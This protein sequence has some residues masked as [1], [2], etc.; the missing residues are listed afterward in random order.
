VAR[1]VLRETL[2]KMSTNISEGLG[3]TID[4]YL[5]VTG[6]REQNDINQLEFKE[7]TLVGPDIQGQICDESKS[8]IAR[9]QMFKVAQET[10]EI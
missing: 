1:K 8:R 7:E 9:T 5:K 6:Q 3:L 2:D 4:K 10:K